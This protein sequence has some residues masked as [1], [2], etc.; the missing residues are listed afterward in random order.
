MRYI[1]F[2]G[3]KYYPS[4]GALDIAGFGDSIDSLV[5][6]QSLQ[7]FIDDNCLFWWHVYDT[8]DREIVAAGRNE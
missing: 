3:D 4:G 7:E 5:A 1:L 6:C 8:E 2:M